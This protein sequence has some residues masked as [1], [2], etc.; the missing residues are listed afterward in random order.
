MNA[1]TSS[2]YEHYAQIGKV[3][4]S[5][6]RIEL[7]ELLSQAPHSV[8][9]LANLTEMGMANTSQH[10]QLL[11]QARLVEAE[12]KGLY[13]IYRLAGP[14]VQTFLSHLAVLAQAQHAEVRQIESE[15]LAQ[16]APWQAVSLDELQARL[17]AGVLLLDVRPASEFAAGHIPGAV[18]APLP[19]LAQRMAELPKE[20]A[21]IA[22][23]RGPYCLFA[24]EAVSLLAGQGYQ[25]QHYREGMA[26]WRE[27][28]LAETHSA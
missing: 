23:C 12:K 21:I 6:R 5:P 27:A 20:Q 15:F 2:L 22:Y 4:T 7:L 8:E 3:L 28:A 1:Y 24:L 17:E 11:R 14:T 26:G 16:S 25:A 13:V 19:E 18:S 9:E 10:L